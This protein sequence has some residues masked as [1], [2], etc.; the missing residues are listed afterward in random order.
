MP[1]GP[2]DIHFSCMTEQHRSSSQFSSSATAQKK[3]EEQ[4]PIP[5]LVNYLGY[6][7]GDA[8]GSGRRSRSKKGRD[9]GSNTLVP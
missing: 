4:Q 6:V 2:V 8:G 3:L 1:D 5:K 7:C 9:G